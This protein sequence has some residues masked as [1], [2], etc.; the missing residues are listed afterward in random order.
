VVRI[1]RS[2]DFYT[3]LMFT[4]NRCPNK[5]C[6]PC[7]DQNSTEFEL[8]LSRCAWPEVSP[9]MIRAVQQANGAPYHRIAYDLEHSPRQR[10]WQAGKE[11]RSAPARQRYSSSTACRIAFRIK[12]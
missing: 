5:A 12:R 11:G 10:L 6:C 1:I 2:S 9:K 4:P 3:E 7:C 8:N